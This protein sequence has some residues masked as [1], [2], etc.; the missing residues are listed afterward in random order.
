MA[1]TAGPQ[2]TFS[3]GTI[4]AKKYR[5]DHV[6]G[7]GGMGIVFAA[8]HLQL[9]Q[10]VAIKL[11]LPDV[12]DNHEVVR[13]FLIEARACSKVR[14]D[15]VTQV[16]D[17]G[18]E[19]GMP[20]M[21]MELLE[22]E[23]FSQLL[24]Q[25]GP[26]PI[27]M[28][29]DC[30]LETCEALSFAHPL[31][32]IHR[33]L[34]PSNLFLTKDGDGKSVVKVL[35]FGISKL[36]ASLDETDS[37]MTR[38]IVTKTNTLLGSPKYMAP[39]QMRSA[40]DADARSDIW[41][42]GIIAFELLT[43]TM[44]FGGDSLMALMVATMND[45]AP[46]LQSRRPDAPPE[47]AAAIAKC[48]E[49]DPANR[50]ASVAELALALA[51]FGSGRAQAEVLRITRSLPS[52]DARMA[53]AAAAWVPNDS[54]ASH[55]RQHPAPTTKRAGYLWAAA[56]AAVV[57][58]LGAVGAWALKTVSARRAPDPMS[59]WE[60]PSMVEPPAMPSTVPSAKEPP[61]PVI[62][63]PAPP[64]KPSA[65]PSATVSAPP[66]PAP[67]HRSRPRPANTVK[68]DTTPKPSTGA[69]IDRHG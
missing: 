13:R 32:I 38:P 58:L 52:S 4:F 12:V 28:V 6:I 62:S 34:K 39:E 8:T 55:I 29:V 41:S 5:L 60:A 65:T 66:E 14:S 19:E 48:L 31:G 46:P 20:Y 37:S 35:D 18:G 27:P 7:K 1:S 57:V 15:H 40:R 45:P 59:T 49:K 26:M 63:E 47:L 2:Q 43:G 56:A 33:D 9:D 25:N 16:F 17:V 24:K 42:L 30:M 68:P 69:A 50:F 61:P 54:V 64:A 67:T 44:P 3:P 51:P 23:N 11:L 53:D 21:V 36:V 22:G 10:K